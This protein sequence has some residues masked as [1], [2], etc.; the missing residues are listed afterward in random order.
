MLSDR[1]DDHG[2]GPQKSPW[3]IIQIYFFDPAPPKNTD[4]ADVGK[5]YFPDLPRA[6]CVSAHVAARSKRPRTAREIWVRCLSEIY[7][8]N[9]QP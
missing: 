3:P 7:A 5:D 8:T 1:H 9:R 2:Q 6:F 4:C